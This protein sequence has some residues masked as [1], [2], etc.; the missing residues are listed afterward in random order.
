MTLG[1]CPSWKRKRFTILGVEWSYEI[2]MICKAYEC[3]LEAGFQTLL[4]VYIQMQTQW[5]VLLF[6]RDLV[7]AYMEDGGKILQLLPGTLLGL[8]INMHNLVEFY[9]QFGDI[10][11]ALSSHGFKRLEPFL[12]PSA[13]S[14]FYLELSCGTSMSRK[15]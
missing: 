11:M 10:I 7:K 14:V 8:Y 6:W 3:A 9:L 2:A 15:S 12:S 13:S 4:Q 5:V 1:L